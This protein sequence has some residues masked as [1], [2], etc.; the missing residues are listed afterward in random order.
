MRGTYRKVSHKWLQGYLNK[1]TWRYNPPAGPQSDVRD[2]AP[3]SGRV[4]RLLLYVWT[5]MRDNWR[6]FRHADREEKAEIWR[7][8]GSG[9]PF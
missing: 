9:P 6:W 2:P 8:T 4:M 7:R 5:K 3:E 1:F